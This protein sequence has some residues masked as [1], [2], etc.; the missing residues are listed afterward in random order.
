[1][2]PH[3][4][5]LGL[6]WGAESH[7]PATHS[8]VGN[9]LLVEAPRRRR[10][11][12]YGTTGCTPARYMLIATRLVVSTNNDRCVLQDLW[13][14]QREMYTQPRHGTVCCI[15]C[16]MA[17]PGTAWHGQSGGLAVPLAVT[18][19]LSTGYCRTPVAATQLVTAPSNITGITT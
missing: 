13:S 6:Q 8:T 17:L 19:T 7:C 15:T 2:L 4:H 10:Y 1:M 16:S 18:R 5:A 12:L 14:A 3:H 11:T 9:L